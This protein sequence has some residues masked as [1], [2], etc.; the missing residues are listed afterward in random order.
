[1]FARRS[2]IDKYR[3]D[4]CVIPGTHQLGGE[5]TRLEGRNVAATLAHYISET[6]GY[7]GGDR[8]PPAGALAPVGHDQRAHPEARRS[9]RTHTSR[10]GTGRL[11]GG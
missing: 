8:P 7:G 5:F 2:H 10:S 4:G 1:M 6:G 3:H 11:I 9:R